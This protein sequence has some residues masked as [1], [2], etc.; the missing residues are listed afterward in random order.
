MATAIAQL[1]LFH[2]FVGR[3]L[4]DGGSELPSPQECLDLWLIENQ[5]PEEQAETLEAIRQGLEDMYAGRTRPAAEVLRD[6]C[7]KHDLPLPQ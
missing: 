4:A 2:E 5:T 1:R 7:R 6:L 3:K